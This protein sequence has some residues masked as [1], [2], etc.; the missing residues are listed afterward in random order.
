MPHSSHK[1]RYAAYC[2]ALAETSAT[3]RAAQA[4]LDSG[5]PAEWFRLT[6]EANE[7]QRQALDEYRDS[8]PAADPAVRAAPAQ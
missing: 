5:D 3:M 1:N 8:A 4:A 2:E 7:R 6:V